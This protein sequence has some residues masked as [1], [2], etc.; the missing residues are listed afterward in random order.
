SLRWSL[1]IILICTRSFFLSFFFS[2]R[3]RLLFPDL[4]PGRDEV[5]C[6]ARGCFE[7]VSVDSFLTFLRL[8][9]PYIIRSSHLQLPF[10]FFSHFSPPVWG[11]VGHTVTAN[12]PQHTFEC[13]IQW[14]ALFQL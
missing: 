2:F 6:A 12:V 4:C 10:V 11:K 14:W 8:F 7:R 5:L 13:R 1:A 9:F 3:H